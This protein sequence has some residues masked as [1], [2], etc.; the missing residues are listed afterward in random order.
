MSSRPGISFVVRG[1]AAAQVHPS[2]RSSRDGAAVP[3]PPSSSGDAPAVPLS[4][5][6]P[7]SAADVALC[8]VQGDFV[9]DLEGLDII[10]DLGRIRADYF[11]DLDARAG[12]M[13]KPQLD[14]QI[15]ALSCVVCS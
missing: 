2:S 9:G 5:S 7:F 8:W 3:A 1:L 13:H 12:Q 15:K 4:H 14:E 6:L 11:A 10:S